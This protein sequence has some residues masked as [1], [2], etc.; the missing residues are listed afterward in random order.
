MSL[1]NASV[2]SSQIREEALRLGFF[3]AGIA[4]AHP[5]SCGN[6]FKKWLREGRHGAMGY[7][8]RQAAIRLDPARVL[9][10][11]RSIV[12]LAMNYCT[13]QALADSPLKGRI[14][15]YAWGGDYHAVVEARLE[16]LL[17]FIRRRQPSVEGLRY[18]DTGPVMEKAWGAETSL[19]W[20]GKNTNLITRERGSWFFIG[21]LLLN[22]ELEEDAGSADFCGKCARCMQAC[23][24]GAIVAPYLLDARLCISYLT[25]EFRGAIPRRLRPLIGNRVFGCDDCQEVCP[26]NRFAVGTAER[27]LTPAEGNLMPDLAPLIRMTPGEFKER[28]RASPVWRA[29]RDGFVRNLAVALGNSG[30]NE[31]VPALEEAVRDKSPLVRAHAAWGLGQIASREACRGLRSALGQESDPEVFEEIHLALQDCGRQRAPEP[32]L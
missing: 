7:L 6:N 2:L 31:A 11:V 1:L 10:S 5:L 4:S 16:R 17:D 8:E 30:M 32:G 25:I 29:T 12:V 28:F 26:W 27:E 15:R 9:S 18:V 22:L 3:K 23:P 19:G 13:G 20:I 21:V 14:S 24:T